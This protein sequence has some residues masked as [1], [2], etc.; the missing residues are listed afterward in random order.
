MKTLISLAF[1]SF[2]LFTNCEGISPYKKTTIENYVANNYSKKEV[3]ITMRDG[4]KLHTTIYSPKDKS[5][6]YPI[7]MQER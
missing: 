2:F 1:F 5:K 7:L 4:I 3:N 6:T